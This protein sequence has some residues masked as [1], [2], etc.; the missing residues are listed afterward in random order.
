MRDSACS[1]NGTIQMVS[2][3]NADDNLGTFFYYLDEM[4]V[5][6]ISR[7]RSRMN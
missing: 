3:V 4:T 5:L 6:N 7:P 2:P 1:L